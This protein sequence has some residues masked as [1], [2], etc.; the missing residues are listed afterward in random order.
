M[1]NTIDELNAMIIKAN[2]V[3]NRRQQVNDFAHSRINEDLVN[4]VQEHR[5]VNGLISNF[6]IM[7]NY[8]RT[9]FFIRTILPSK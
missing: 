2:F 4:A 5:R 8:L 1:A 3:E 9:K 6:S 7:K